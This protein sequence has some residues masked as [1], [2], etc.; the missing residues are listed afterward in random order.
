M[1]LERRFI[2]PVA[3]FGALTLVTLIVAPLVGPT[4][5]SLR[6]AFDF[7]IPFADNVDGA[8]VARLEN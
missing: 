7:S 2:R 1:T 4:S 3:G 5:I 6:R 8:F